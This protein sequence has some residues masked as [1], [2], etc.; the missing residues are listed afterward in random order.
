MANSPRNSSMRISEKTN[1]TID[2][3]TSQTISTPS[4]TNPIRT[5][6]PSLRR[7]CR[8]IGPSNLELPDELDAP[9]SAVDVVAVG[10]GQRGPVALRLASGLLPSRLGSFEGGVDAVL[11]D[12]AGPFH[13]RVD[14][15][16][17]GHHGHVL[18]PHEQVALLVAGGDAQVGVAGLAGSVDDAAHD[19]HLQ[20]DLLV[21]ERLLR[22]ARHLDHVD[23]GPAARG[24]GDEVDVLALTEPH[25]LEKRP[26][27][28]GLLHRV[29]GEAVADRVA[30][31][32]GQ[33]RGDA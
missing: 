26:T 31:A 7:A 21:P 15:L 22:L 19:R 20:R 25:G 10:A 11:V 17:L 24:A 16:I 12:E 4:S 27:G 33:Q 30:D 28:P 18:P 1:P 6:H 9:L 14:H 23:L 2:E 8:A 13:Q 5:N 3:M 32:L 29:G